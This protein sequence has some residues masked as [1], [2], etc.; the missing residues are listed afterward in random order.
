MELMAPTN[1]LR[2]GG[3]TSRFVSLEDQL[4]VIR[5]LPEHTGII[6]LVRKVPNICIGIFNEIPLSD[7]SKFDGHTL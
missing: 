7:L 3:S 1:L 4:T 6:L 5:V 2:Y